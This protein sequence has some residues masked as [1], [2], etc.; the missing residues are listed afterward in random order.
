MEIQPEININLCYY[1]YIIHY[2]RHALTLKCRQK[3]F[4]DCLFADFMLILVLMC[5]CIIIF[6]R[7]YVC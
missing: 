4:I 1:T 2:I 5:V 7:F 6:I 3:E